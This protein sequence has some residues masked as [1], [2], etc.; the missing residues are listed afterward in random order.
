MAKLVNSIG[1]DD[2][3]ANVD[4]STMDRD[5]LKDV[6]GMIFPETKVDATPIDNLV[7]DDNEEK[8]NQQLGDELGRRGDD[9]LPSELGGV[10]GMG[11]VFINSRTHGG[12]L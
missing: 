11:E 8:H 5:L 1:S 3:D 4:M 9:E 6:L 10:E 12:E 2:I 7:V